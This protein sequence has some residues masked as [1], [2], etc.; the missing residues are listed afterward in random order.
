MM[1]FKKFLVTAKEN[2]AS[3]LHLVVGEP[4]VVRLHGFLNRL[5]SPKII[6]ADV[7]DVVNDILTGD[8]KEYLDK[9]GAID[10]GFDI[11]SAGRFRIN[12]FKERKGFGVAFRI[13]PD[14][15]KTIK[16]L[17]LP[18]VI[19]SVVS[20]EKG[21]VLVTGPTGSGKSTTLASIIDK[22][23]IECEKHIIT[24][25]DPIEFVHEHKNCIVHQR[26]IGLHATSFKDALRSSFREDPDVILVGEMRDLDTISMA[27]TAA[28]TGH[29]VLATLHT[30]GAPQ[31]INRIIDA[32]PSDQQEQVRT[33]LSEVLSM[34]M[35][36]VLIPNKQLNGRV[37]ATELLFGTSAIS[38][39]IREGK[40][41]QIYS[42]IQTSR[43][44]GMHDMD[45]C[46]KLLHDEG[47]IG[48]DEYIKRSTK[49]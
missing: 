47:L 39:L 23:N 11:E 35:S 3:D 36:Q 31:T 48:E 46:L 1:D 24:I 37:V 32:F 16:E 12:V 7:E 26:E 17:G 27:I 22:I 40:T 49:G 33:Q 45:C 25:E 2:G 9:N 43:K 29:V 20:M 21:L 5:K 41:H 10:L 30:I 4:P 8:Q 14:K 42:V 44:L 18:E 34:V 15:I 13:I 28:E 6:R 38:N 19:N